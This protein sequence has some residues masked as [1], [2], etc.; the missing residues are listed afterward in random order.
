MIM[1]YLT[2]HIPHSNMNKLIEMYNFIALCSFVYFK[3]MIYLLV[4]D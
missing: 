2:N 3:L 4:K 1:I